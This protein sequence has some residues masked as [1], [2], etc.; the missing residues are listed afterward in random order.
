[1][2]NAENAE[3]AI[4]KKGRLT[5][6][7]LEWLNERLGTDFPIADSP[8]DR[9]RELRDR[10][11]GITVAGYSN[12]DVLKAV[13]CGMADYGIAGEDKLEEL[14][15]PQ[16]NPYRLPEGGFNRYGNLTAIGVVQPALCRLVLARKQGEETRPL[17]RIATSYPNL[18]K[19]MLRR[20]GVA[21]TQMPQVDVFSGGVEPIARRNGYDAI[22]DVTQTGETLRENGFVE[23]TQIKTY[24]SV[25]VQCYRDPLSPEL[26]DGLKNNS[27]MDVLWRRL[28]QRKISPTSS[29]A[30]KLVRDPGSALRKWNEEKGEFEVAFI[31]GDV[32]EIELEAADVL[33]SLCA[34]L[35][36]ADVDPNR[37]MTELAGRYQGQ[38]LQAG[39]FKNERKKLPRPFGY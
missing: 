30:S 37:V 39:Y 29:L 32:P 3:F 33:F 11:T 18:T 34:M 9:T 8:F 13:A 4:Q 14:L 28:Q 27:V 10:A 17:R 31:Q 5:K 6:G 12:G 15:Y 23:T 38:N 20:T 2:I 26:F 22:V 21:I 25:V 19:Q 16:N 1:M 36:Q 24:S 7:S 35:V